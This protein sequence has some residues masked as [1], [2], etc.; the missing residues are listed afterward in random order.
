[1]FFFHEI[2]WFLDGN[3]VGYLKCGAIPGAYS[4]VDFGVG[5]NVNAS[6]ES[7]R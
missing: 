5:V 7:Q 3:S 1:M 2:T 4:T 6:F